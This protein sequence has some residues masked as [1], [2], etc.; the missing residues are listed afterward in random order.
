MA[1]GH[2][3]VYVDPIMKFYIEQ[4]TKKLTEQIKK[5]HGLKTLRVPFITGSQWLGNMLMGKK[6][7]VRYRVKKISLNEGVLEFL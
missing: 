2:D 6:A 1:N 7:M 4:E 5:Q 3:R